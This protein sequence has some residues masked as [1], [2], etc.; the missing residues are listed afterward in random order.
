M[1]ALAVVTILWVTV[2]YTLAFTPGDFIGDF[3]WGGLTGVNVNADQVESRLIAC[4]K[5]IQVLAFM[6]FQM[7][8]A[9]LTPVLVGGAVA[10]R[11]KIQFWVLF[12]A[13]WHIFVYVFVAKWIFGY[14][15]LAQRG[16]LDYAGFICLLFRIKYFDFFIFLLYNLYFF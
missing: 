2:G 14:G 10:G 4:P 12:V 3:R 11:M 9:T 16:G 1:S 5:S 8:F 7:A 13:A 6:V 15:W